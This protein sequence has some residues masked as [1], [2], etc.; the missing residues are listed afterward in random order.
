MA[1]PS[2]IPHPP[3]ED[4]FIIRA[5]Y[6][7]LFDDFCC[8]ALLATFEY[9]HN[10]ELM[11]L[12]RGCKDGEPLIEARI[13]DI[14]AEMLGMYSN[15]PIVN[16]LKRL[17]EAGLVVRVSKG[18]GDRG[19]YRFDA[20][21]IIEAIHQKTKFGKIT[22]LEE[23]ENYTTSEEKVV[24]FSG[25]T[26]QVP[27]LY[28][29]CIKKEEEV[30]EEGIKPKSPKKPLE[31][32]AYFELLEKTA[33]RVD[34]W[35]SWK[36]GE[37]SDR[38]DLYAPG[39][40]IEFDVIN[41]D[42]FSAWIDTVF[43]VMERKTPAPPSKKHQ[44]A[45]INRI[46]A[47]GKEKVVHEIHEFFETGGNSL[48]KLISGWKVKFNQRSEPD[49]FSPSPGRSRVGASGGF[50]RQAALG[51]F[52]RERYSSEKPTPTSEAHAWNTAVP[53][54]EWKF[55]TLELD[56]ALN[57]R[58]RDIDFVN[59]YS[60]VLAKCAKIAEL[61]HKMSSYVTFSWILKENNWM[62]V[63]N[64]EL[65]FMLKAEKSKRTDVDTSMDALIE[66][67]RKGENR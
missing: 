31:G 52:K 23:V 26:T 53:S 38:T 55:W 19:V 35:P 57:E 48:D 24:Y 14:E 32:D 59:C 39:E 45:M 4:F 2:I 44:L 34:Q 67:A 62:K 15:K 1:R 28:P 37:R 42:N 21:A 17:H 61:D 6:L 22:Q 20:N 12:Q 8:A 66:K 10:G 33:K 46:A 43:T 56:M 9:W 3:S 60:Q 7:T 58:L 65:D 51:S 54:R 49:S 50:N 30:R 41:V 11:Q 64:G 36:T 25:K 63:M 16:A 13:S 18:R 29:L 40:I 47:I 5:N 27:P